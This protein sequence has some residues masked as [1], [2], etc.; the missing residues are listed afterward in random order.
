MTSHVAS[1]HGSRE[2]RRGR[3]LEESKALLFKVWRMSG[4]SVFVSRV[5]TGCGMERMRKTG[6]TRSHC[7]STGW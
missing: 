5:G 2:N 7:G 1:V 6:T 4:S 3:C